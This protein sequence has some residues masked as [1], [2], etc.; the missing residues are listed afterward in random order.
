ML[1][2]PVVKTRKLKNFSF[3]LIKQ[4]PSHARYSNNLSIMVNNGEKE[5]RVTFNPRE[6]RALQRFLEENLQNQD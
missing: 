1:K 5:H 2:K 6:A 4:N 3:S